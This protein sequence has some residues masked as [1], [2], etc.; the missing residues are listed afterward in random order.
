[1]LEPTLKGYIYN[2]NPPGTE[3]MTLTRQMTT[4]PFAYFKEY[5][6]LR[7]INCGEFN[8]KYRVIMNTYWETL[9]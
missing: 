3:N 9:Y 7:P 4:K 8:M 5:T 6:E 1:M 2:I